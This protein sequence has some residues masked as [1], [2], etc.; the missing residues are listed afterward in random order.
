MIALSLLKLARGA[1]FS[2]RRCKLRLRLM[3]IERGLCASCSNRILQDLT[4]R[5]DSKEISGMDS[6]DAA[7]A[8]SQNGDSVVH[9]GWRTLRL[10]FRAGDVRDLSEKNRF[11]LLVSIGRCGHRKMEA[12]AVHLQRALRCSSESATKSLHCS[13]GSWLTGKPLTFTKH[14]QFSGVA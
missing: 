8:I 3:F 6:V 11:L 14:A 5:V 10:R 4:P 12:T 1:S 2:F 9:C 7:D 13:S